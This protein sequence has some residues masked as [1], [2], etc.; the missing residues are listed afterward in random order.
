MENLLQDV[1]VAE[2]SAKKSEKK[3]EIEILILSKKKQKEITDMKIE[4]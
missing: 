4:K 2:R 3:T 1:S